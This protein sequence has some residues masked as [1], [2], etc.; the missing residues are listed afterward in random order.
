MIIS[1]HCIL[2]CHIQVDSRWLLF[3]AWPLGNLQFSINSYCELTQG[4]LSQQVQTISNI[5]LPQW[6]NELQ[7]AIWALEIMVTDSE[8]VGSFV[9]LLFVC[10]SQLQERLPHLLLV[11]LPIIALSYT[12]DKMMRRKIR[13]GSSITA[14]K[15][16][17]RNSLAALGMCTSMCYMYIY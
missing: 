17:R 16:K 8:T 7:T 6:E 4:T 3:S 13:M 9:K 5:K 15:K 12:G 14:Y 10:P 1:W 11:K 2:S